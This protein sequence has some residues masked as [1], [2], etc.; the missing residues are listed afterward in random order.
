MD[1]HK[2]K[3]KIS[4]IKYNKSDWAHLMNSSQIVWPTQSPRV[5]I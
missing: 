5:I 4:G 3:L 2:L 1:Y